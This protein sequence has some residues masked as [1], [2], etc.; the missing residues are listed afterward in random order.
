[1]HAWRKQ[2]RNRARA[3][4][5]APLPRAPPLPLF[6]RP[7]R[8]LSRRSANKVAAN[9]AAFTPEAKAGQDTYWVR[10]GD[11]RVVPAVMAFIGLNTVLMV[12]G[13]SKRAAGRSAPGESAPAE[14][15]R[16]HSGTRLLRGLARF[17]VAARACS[18][19]E[20]LPRAPTLLFSLLFASL[21]ACGT[22]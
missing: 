20:L 17:A 22:G 6:S 18:A 11:K 5:P 15:M 2:A 12:A 7:V 8:R 16:R 1:M 19:S 10:A 14:T 21:Q 4:A 13:A 9:Q 3:P